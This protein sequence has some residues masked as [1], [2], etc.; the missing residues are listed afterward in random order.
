MD[1]DIGYVCECGHKFHKGDRYCA[2]C[3]REKKPVR[4]GVAVEHKEQPLHF[5]PAGKMVLAKPLEP[6]PLEPRH[7]KAFTAPFAAHILDRHLPPPLNLLSKFKLIMGADPMK[8]QNFG[9]PGKLRLD[10][11]MPF[12]LQMDTAD[13]SR[14][15]E[16]TQR[17]AMKQHIIDLL[18]PFCLV[19]VKF[20]NTHSIM[21]LQEISVKSTMT[22]G[23]K[24]ICRQIAGGAIYEPINNGNDRMMAEVRGEQHILVIH[25]DKWIT[26]VPAKTFNMCSVCRF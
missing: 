20:F 5:R 14:I 12:S 26:L 16:I 25:D 3:T 7:P 2:M 1:A 17:Q 8:A 4:F 24:R 18:V 22:R 15:Y 19:Q 23:R 6:L 9:K 10:S 13:S 21:Q 11:N